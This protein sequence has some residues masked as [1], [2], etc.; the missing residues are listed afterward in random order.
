MKNFKINKEGK[1]YKVVMI[2][3]KVLV[4]IVLLIMTN[5]LFVVSST[6]ER[7]CG[8]ILLVFVTIPTI[9]VVFFKNRVL[10]EYPGF[11]K[12]WRALRV[13]YMVIILLFIL[14]I[15]VGLVRFHIKL[16]TAKAVKY[17]YA[18][19]I[20]LKDAMGENLPP[21]PNE[22]INNSTLGGLDANNNLVRDDVELAIFKKYPDSAK[23]R[24]AALQYAQALQLEL[25]KVYNS[26][27]MTAVANKKSAGYFCMGNQVIIKGVVNKSEE[28]KLVAKELDKREQ[29]IASLVLNTDLRTNKQAAIFKKYMTSS[30]GLPE[31][32]CDVDSSLLPN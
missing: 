20:T 15:A 22:Q 32:E 8:I 30:A 11:A 3:W 13:V 24:A 6:Q 31:N 2:I 27:T 12:P 14:V 9:F 10:A 1:P 28:M 7:Y 21:V 4:A 17:I 26:E 23:N 5:G 18:Q 16:N 25:T 19:K 29:D